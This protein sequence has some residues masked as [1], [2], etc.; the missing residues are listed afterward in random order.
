MPKTTSTATTEG[1]KV[2]VES[3][4]VAEQS[5]PREG[6]YVFA[7]RVRI[8][9]RGTAT[10]QLR[11]RHWLVTDAFGG[12]REVKGPGVVGEQPVLAP[13]DVFEYSSGSMLATQRG[14]MHG[15]YQ[16]EREDGTS[17]DAEIATFLLE[18]PYSLN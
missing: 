13:G 3:R 16:M 17:F 9:N 14:T 10:V 15:S 1:V 4:Y 6:R 12:V 18:M 7:Y 11:S 2:T 5:R 8:E